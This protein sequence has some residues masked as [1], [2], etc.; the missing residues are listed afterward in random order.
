MSD[1]GSIQQQADDFTKALGE[2]LSDLGSLLAKD[3][4]IPDYL[5]AGWMLDQVNNMTA[6]F[7]QMH[8]IAGNLATRKEKDE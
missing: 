7:E 4:D 3:S 1:K 2:M 8:T 6:A 5:R